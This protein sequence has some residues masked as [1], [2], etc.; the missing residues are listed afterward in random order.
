VHL[1]TAGADV[2]S[3]VPG[4]YDSY[5]GTSMAAPGVAGDLAF[6]KGFR[7]N[8]TSTQIVDLFKKYTLPDPDSMGKVNFH[9]RP[10]VFSA[11]E[12]LLKP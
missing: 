2:Y 7:P 4:G 8:L 10:D 5:S 1:S 9:G 11:F 3:T 6:L 12:H